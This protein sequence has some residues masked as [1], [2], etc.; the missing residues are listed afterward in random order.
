MHCHYTG[1]EMPRSGKLL[2]N[3][4][5]LGTCNVCQNLKHMALFTSIR[6]GAAAAGNRTHNLG[7]SSTT[8]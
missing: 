8:P 2:K 1:D 4:D 3:F 6:K 5:H 7:L